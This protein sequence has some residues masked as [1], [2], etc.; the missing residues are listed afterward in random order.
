[1]ISRLVH[2]FAGAA[3]VAFVL[4]LLAPASASAAGVGQACG[5]ILPIQCDSGTFCELPTGRCGGD[6][7][8][9]CVK[10]PGACILPVILRVCGCDNKTYNSNCFRQQAKVSKLHNGACKTPKY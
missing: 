3:I 2:R 7:R 1:M 9:K 5:G 8:G 6:V 4:V 10:V